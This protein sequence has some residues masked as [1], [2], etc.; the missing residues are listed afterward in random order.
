[1]VT[2]EQ[3]GEPQEYVLYAIRHDGNYI[4]RLTIDSR[5]QFSNIIIFDNKR[6]FPVKV[7]SEVCTAIRQEFGEM[8]IRVAN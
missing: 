3:W 8:E 2:F 5:P 6:I 7:M 1:M 4:A